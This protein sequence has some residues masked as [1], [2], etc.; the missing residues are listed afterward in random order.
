MT[1]PPPPVDPK[2][3]AAAPTANEKSVKNPKVKMESAPKAIIGFP[4]K[5]MESA[6]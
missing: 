4:K 5:E 3:K 2:A 1:K 6:L